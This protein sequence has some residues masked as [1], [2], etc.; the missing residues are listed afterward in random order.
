[1]PPGWRLCARWHLDPDRRQGLAQPAGTALAELPGGRT[2][3]QRVQE[4]FDR[5]EQ[6]G[7]VV[8]HPVDQLV[9]VPAF[10][11]RVRAEA[12][13]GRAGDGV[14]AKLT[15]S[16]QITAAHRGRGIGVD[17]DL[18]GA[19]EADRGLGGSGAAARFHGPV[20]RQS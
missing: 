5:V 7:A 1:M 14:G 16:L 13:Q 6:V 9:L 11:D 17:L 8:A 15:L 4:V 2:D 3:G 10:G 20:R 19:D 12:D 18:A